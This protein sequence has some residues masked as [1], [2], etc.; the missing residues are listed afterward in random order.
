LRIGWIA[1]ADAVP[2]FV[3][4]GVTAVV[5]LVL[6]PFVEYAWHWLW[7][8]SE[9]LKRDYAAAIADISVPKTKIASI[10]ASTPKPILTLHQID[11]RVFLDVRN[12]GAAGMFH[13]QI[14][15]MEG[16]PDWPMKH[17]SGR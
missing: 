4:L 10:A 5:V 15:K 16:V 7:A 13:L 8:P 6:R 3:E 11:A 14:E 1:K 9:I 17:V 2:W 12:E